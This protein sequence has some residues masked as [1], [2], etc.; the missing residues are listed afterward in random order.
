M[1]K[2]FLLTCGPCS[3]PQLKK[4][5]QVY[6]QLCSKYHKVELMTYRAGHAGGS[7]KASR[8]KTRLRQGQA[9]LASRPKGSHLVLM[10]EK[11]TTFS[12]EKLSATRYS[13][14]LKDIPSPICFAF[15]GAFGFHESLDQHAAEKI[16]LSNLTTTHELALVI[17]LEQ[18]YRLM[19]IEAGKQYHY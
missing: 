15:G 12:T 3:D 7:D 10:S 8:E 14:W 11:G 13:A 19:A 2:F 18:L 9:L 6:L 17:W 16:S 5:S 1:S 4:L